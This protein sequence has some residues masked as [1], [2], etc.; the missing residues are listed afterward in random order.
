MLK[1]LASAGFFLLFAT[2]AGACQSASQSLD[3]SLPDAPSARVTTLSEFSGGGSF[4]LKLSA[5]GSAQIWRQSAFALPGT[6]VSN[7]EW[8]N[9]FLGKYLNAAAPQ[10][11]LSARSSA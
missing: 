11:G 2:C 3:E 5:M 7:Q 1:R 8:S 4:D 9:T 6:N 10:R